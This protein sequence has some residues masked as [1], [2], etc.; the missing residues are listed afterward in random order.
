MRLTRL[1]VFHI[2][3]FPRYC[4]CE[5]Y[6]LSC[7]LVSFRCTYEDLC[8]GDDDV[9]MMAVE[10]FAKTPKYSTV[11]DNVADPNGQGAVNTADVI[12]GTDAILSL[13]RSL[14]KRS[15]EE[16]LKQ[17]ESQGDSSNP[18]SGSRDGSNAASGSRSR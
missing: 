2:L 6:G 7:V 1:I 11:N 12:E 15:R 16:F 18:A 13:K 8:C 9:E 17:V 5:S 14:L 3:E 4:F 10:T